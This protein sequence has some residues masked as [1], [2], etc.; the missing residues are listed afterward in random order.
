MLRVSDTQYAALEAY[1]V[2]EFVEQMARHLVVSFP[3]ECQAKGRHA[4][5]AFIRASI[6][7][8]RGQTIKATLEADFRRYIVAEFV[9][10]VDATANVVASE[11]ARLLERDGEV[12][13]TI[14]IFLTYQAL[15]AKIMP[16]GPPPPLDVEYEAVA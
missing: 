5:L 15:L 14:L 12:D 10:G 7:R 16:E 13:P 9:L 1:F 3:I 6:Q 8:A 4:L 11:R 2:E